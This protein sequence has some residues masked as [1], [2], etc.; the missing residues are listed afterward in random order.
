MR[1]RN[2]LKD[3]NDLEKSRTARLF[4]KVKRTSYR[5]TLIS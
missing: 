3:E 4:W 5:Y 2:T 1:Q